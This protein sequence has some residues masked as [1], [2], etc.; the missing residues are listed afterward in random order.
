MQITKELTLPIHGRTDEIENQSP[1]ERLFDNGVPLAGSSRD[2]RSMRKLFLFDLLV[3]WISGGTACGVEAA[4]G[5]NIHNASIAEIFVSES[6]GFLFLFSVL[7]V[8]FANIHGLYDFPWK[9][10]IHEDLK[11]LAKSVAAAAVVAGFYFHLGGITTVS[12]GT[13][14]LTIGLTWIVLLVSRKLIHPQAL[15]GPPEVRNVLIVGPGRAGRLL[16]AHLERNPEL[17]YVVKGF[18]SRRRTARPT[19]K[20]MVDLL[21]AVDQ[22]PSIARAHFIDEIFISVP[23]D[24]HLVKEIARFARAAKVQVRVIPDLYD[25]LALEQPIEYIGCFPTLTVNKSPI[26]PVALVLKRLVDIVGSAIALICFAPLLAV[27]ALIIKIDSKGPVFYSGLRVG[28]KGTTFRCHKFRTMLA[29]AEALQASLGHLNQRDKIL[30]KI[31][32]DP[33]I[34]RVGRYLRKFSID[35]IPQFWNVLK[36]EMSLVGP[37]PAACN[38]YARYDL[39]HLCRLHVTPGITGLWQVAGRLDPSFDSYISLDR[40]YVNNWSLGLD[41]KILCKTVSTVL[42]GTGQ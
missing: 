4:W 31:T 22:L 41:C 8:L 13:F 7:V 20:P 26:P 39:E 11:L 12:N 30:F 40:E 2:Q 25:G 36:G 14:M 9:R 42:A 16:Q 17:G 23:Q 32:N 28:K 24:R 27:V 37:R 34:T 29:N 1:I 38:E 19:D 6:F 15:L 35:E 3:I 5:R 33:R 21:G 18:L 10:T